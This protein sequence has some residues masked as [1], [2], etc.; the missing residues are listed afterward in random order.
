ML[1][2]NALREFNN[3]TNLFISYGNG[4]NFEVHSILVFQS[5]PVCPFYSS[6]F[7]PYFTA[8]TSKSLE[9]LASALAGMKRHNFGTCCFQNSAHFSTVY[10]ISFCLCS[11]GN[12]I[13][14]SKHQSWRASYITV[15]SINSWHADC[16]FR[17]VAQE[18]CYSGGK[19]FHVMSQFP[20]NFQAL[21]LRSAYNVEVSSARKVLIQ[22][23]TR[24]VKFCRA[25]SVDSW[26]I[27]RENLPAFDRYQIRGI[28]AE[29][30][31]FNISMSVSIL[32]S[33]C[34]RDLLQ[35]SKF[36]L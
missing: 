10:Q 34:H 19:L 16:E 24:L 18:S 17:V 30:L 14:H 22:L 35:H 21:C 15:Y 7:W 3:A 36:P 33:V 23:Y 25:F 29:V 11:F 9:L 1:S 20:E 12:G 2:I 31:F 26:Y 27:L 5:Q 32:I 6:T 13:L 4:S 8:L 28:L